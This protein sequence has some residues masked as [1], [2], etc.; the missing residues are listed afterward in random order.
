MTEESWRRAARE[1]H[2]ERLRGAH[3]LMG[4]VLGETCPK[5]K[6]NAP[7]AT[8]IA[9][10]DVALA[11]D[12]AVQKWFVWDGRRWAIDTRLIVRERAKQTCKKAATRCQQTKIQATMA[13]A[14]MKVCQP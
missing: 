4:G 6:A 2:A 5:P 11:H 1:Y 12:F 3:S 9:L 14:F 13:L 7:D 8:N 10:S